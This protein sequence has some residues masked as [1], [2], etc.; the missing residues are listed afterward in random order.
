MSGKRKLQK[1]LNPDKQKK[2]TTIA[3]ENTPLGT[4]EIKNTAMNQVIKKLFEEANKGNFSREVYLYGKYISKLKDKGFA[5]PKIQKGNF[6]QQFLAEISWK[7]AFKNASNI[8]LK[9]NPIERHKIVEVL[10]QYLPQLLYITTDIALK[11]MNESLD[12]NNGNNA[13]NGANLDTD[14][15]NDYR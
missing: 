12:G 3:L 15:S 2:A 7:D 5:F 9:E 4:I 10:Y 14:D 11:R 8:D 6:S 1:P 13:P